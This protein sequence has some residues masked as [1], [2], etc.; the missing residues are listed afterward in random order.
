MHGHLSIEPL[1]L[2]P[3]VIPILCEWFETQWSDYYGPGGKGSALQDLKACAHQGSLPVGMV[4]LQARRVCGFAALKAKSIESH[5]HLL[6]WAAA[7]LVHP[8]CGAGALAACCWVLLRSKRASRGSGASIAPPVPHT[9]SCSAGDGGCS[10]AS[11]T[12]AS[13]LAST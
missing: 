4:A 10:T 9:A 8:G 5:S 6:P 7:G 13:V 11:S 12:T 3:Q 2:Y 1:A